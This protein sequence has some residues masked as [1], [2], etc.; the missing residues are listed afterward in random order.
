MYH[1][2]ES[3]ENIG[4]YRMNIEIFWS[5]FAALCAWSIIAAGVR[6][7]FLLWFQ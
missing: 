4:R 5:V 1:S 6:F 2:V 7:L 3:R